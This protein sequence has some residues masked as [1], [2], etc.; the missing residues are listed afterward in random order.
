MNAFLCDVML[1]GLARYLRAAG[2]DTAL[3]DSDA[4]DAEI[5]RQ[6]AE[7]G[8]ILLT[9][10]RKILEHKAA[11]DRTL[12]LPHG[13]LETQAARLSRE[14]GLDWLERAFTRCL[15]DN[16]VLVEAD[17]GQLA[18]VPESARHANE[19]FLA[20]PLC[21]RVYWQGSHYRR[22]LRK[23]AEFQGSGE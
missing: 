23:L 20:C 1:A 17:A 18:R 6:A 2:I 13:A 9:S 5:L 4:T 8:R 14:F 12:L 7:Q 11:R 15:I 3:A 19:R 22:M 10:D 16:A 21:Q